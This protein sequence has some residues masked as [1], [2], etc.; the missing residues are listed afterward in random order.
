VRP[1]PSTI[2]CVKYDEFFKSCKIIIH[3]MGH[4]YNH[5]VIQHKKNNVHSKKSIE[6][7][8]VRI[9]YF[10]YSRLKSDSYNT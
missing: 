5:Y 8:R 1:R 4:I 3:I 7:I 6:D 2:L 9:V 10:F